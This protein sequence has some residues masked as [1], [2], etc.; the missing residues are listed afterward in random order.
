MSKSYPVQ[1]KHSLLINAPTENVWA[2]ITDVAQWPQRFS[3]VKAAEL[4]GDFAVGN[5]FNWKSGGVNIVSTIQALNPHH[6]LHWTGKALGTKAVHTWELSAKGNQTFL[7]T[8]ESFD[9]W[10]VKLMP[11]AFQKMLDKT[12]IDWLSEI[13]RFAEK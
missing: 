2:I 6:F 9:G 12:L 7:E 5:S 11:G 3:H 8:S 13:K 10:L 4:N 1:A